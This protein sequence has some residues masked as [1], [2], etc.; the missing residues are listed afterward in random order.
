MVAIWLYFVTY[1][2][3]SSAIYICNVY[4]YAYSIHKQLF[5]M[6]G[7]KHTRVFNFT[8]EEHIC[9]YPWPVLLLL[10]SLFSSTTLEWGLSGWLVQ[11]LNKRTHKHYAI[12]TLAY[13]T[14]SVKP[15]PTAAHSGSDRDSTTTKAIQLCRQSVNHEAHW[16]AG[17]TLLFFCQ[18]VKVSV[19]EEE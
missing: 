5:R 17:H 16:G 18:R 4:M 9:F 14:V 10:Y 15:A 12:N 2:I 3:M 11:M 7:L 6:P 8:L 13:K 1:T 19:W